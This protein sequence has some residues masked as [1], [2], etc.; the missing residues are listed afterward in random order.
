M[1]G[2]E[3]HVGWKH[4]LYMIKDVVTA[5]LKRDFF[6]FLKSEALNLKSGTER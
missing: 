2:V 5:V 6:N 4:A 1:N 3:H